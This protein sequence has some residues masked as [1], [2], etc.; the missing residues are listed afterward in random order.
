MRAAL[1][2]NHRGHCCI[3]NPHMTCTHTRT[4]IQLLLLPAPKVLALT[5]C[6]TW[7]LFLV[8]LIT[9][10]LKGFAALL[11]QECCALL[12]PNL[13]QSPLT[14]EEMSHTLASTH[15]SKINSETSKRTCINLCTYTH[16]RENNEQGSCIHKYTRMHARTF[17]PTGLSP[18]PGLHS[19]QVRQALADCWMGDL[20]EGPQSHSHYSG[21]PPLSTLH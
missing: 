3:F 16:S 15:Q 20:V 13:S 14:L 7:P 21:F 11:I 4:H 18:G 12:R 5:E 8:L 10:V 9:C 17:S 1:K 19:E 2:V 6:P